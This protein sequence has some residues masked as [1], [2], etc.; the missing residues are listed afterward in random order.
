MEWCRKSLTFLSGLPAFLVG[1]LIT[2]GLDR[3]GLSEVTAFLVSMPV[4]LFAW[5]YFLGRLLEYWAAR[6]LLTRHLPL[7][8]GT[9]SL[10]LAVYVESETP[11]HRRGSFYLRDDLPVSSLSQNRVGGTTCIPIAVS[12]RSGLLSAWLVLNVAR[13]Y[14]YEPETPSLWAWHERLIDLQ[15]FLGWA[16]AVLGAIALIWALFRF[17]RWLTGRILRK[18]ASAA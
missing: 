4:L 10:M 7:T 9:F 12:T 3:L 2:S 8:I 15:G 6:N 13:F 14:T 5:Y 17:S 1:F 16:I 18:H 11:L